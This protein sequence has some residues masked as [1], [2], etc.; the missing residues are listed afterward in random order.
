[1]PTV[2]YI[3]GWRFFF[4]SNEGNEPPHIHV[5]KD[6]KSG[7]FWLNEDQ[8][9]IKLACADK[10]TETDLRFIRKML[11]SHFDEFIESWYD[12]KRELKNGQT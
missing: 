5:R 10:L 1:M 9:E 4:Y 6:D 11:Y 8:W 7:K 12:F 3:K 2:L